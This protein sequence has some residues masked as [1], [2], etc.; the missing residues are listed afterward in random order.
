MKS[1]S[2]EHKITSCCEYP[3]H[4]S[5]KTASVYSARFLEA[6]PSGSAEFQIADY[7][8]GAT[9]DRVFLQMPDLKLRLQIHLVI[10]FRP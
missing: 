5:K 8:D 6:A 4:L 7:I 1:F 9:D 3:D 10:V 2:P